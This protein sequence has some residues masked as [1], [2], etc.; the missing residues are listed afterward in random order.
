MIEIGSQTAP[1]TL[2]TP[3]ALVYSP[4]SSRSLSRAGPQGNRSAA[5][6]VAGQP[7]HASA[8]EPADNGARAQ[9]DDAATPGSD[10]DDDDDLMVVKRRDALDVAADA[11]AEAAPVGLDVLGEGDNK[12]S[13][14]P[15]AALHSAVWA[16]EAHC[17]A[18]IFRCAWSMRDPKVVAPS[19]ASQRVAFRSMLF[20]TAAR[21]HPD[22][23]WLQV[24]QTPNVLCC[25]T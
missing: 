25:H 24:Q 23:V 9:P 3:A 4:R 18:C 17:C 2:R 21:Q 7:A 5:S 10:D 16:V 19:A 15:D 12:C 20:R 6:A 13:L 8:H 22:L 11:A 14:L 1:A